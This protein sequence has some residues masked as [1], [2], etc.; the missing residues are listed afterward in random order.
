MSMS[1]LAL[2][3]V[4][5]ACSGPKATPQ[6]STVT[7]VGAPRCRPQARLV[8]PVAVHSQQGSFQHFSAYVGDG[9]AEVLAGG[10]DGEVT[11]KFGICPNPSGGATYACSSH[12]H[13]GVRYYAER[14]IDVELAKPN[15]LT[16]P[17]VAPNPGD[18]LC[19]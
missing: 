10:T 6:P 9:E 2:L 11:L 15:T 18:L 19:P 4:V 8:H 1:R 12:N 5:V 13:D 14:T 16:V 3:L 7:L 17:F